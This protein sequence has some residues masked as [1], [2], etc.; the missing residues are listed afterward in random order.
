MSVLRTQFLLAAAVLLTTGTLRA[1]S[2]FPTSPLIQIGE[3]TDIFFDA[4]AS[5]S[6]TD[7][8]YSSTNKVSGTS[9]SLA[10]GF[11]LEY[12]KDSPIYAT[13]TMQRAQVRYLG[14]STLSALDS[15][16]DTITG[17]VFIDQGGPLKVTLRSSYVESTRNDNLTSLGIDGSQ[18]GETLVRQGNYLHDL[19]LDYRLTEITFVGL[20]FTNSYNRY[21]N[22]VVIKTETGALPPLAAYNYNYNTNGL[23]E[24]NTKDIELRATYQY[25]GDRLKYGFTYTHSQ[26]DFS[27]A[28]Y[29][30]GTSPTGGT[31]TRA[32][33]IFK[34]VKNV[35][36]LNTTG[37]LTRSGKLRADASVGFSTTTVSDRVAGDTKN[38]GLTYAIGLKHSLTDLINHEINLSR[39]TATTPDG[40]D[41]QTNSY[42][43]AISYSASDS[44]SVNFRLSKSDVDAGPT[45]ISTLGYNLG[46]FYNYNSHL[47]LSASLNIL[48]TQFPGESG[49]DFQSKGLLIQ[50]TFRY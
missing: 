7:N 19:K 30:S 38:S 48:D 36:A 21:L 6:S 37:A 4:V 1:V 39:S 42:V 46:A 41:S 35:F 32:V 40:A 15:S 50:A 17:A 27:A 45:Q 22:P 11:S 33:D 16:Q 29:Y 23:S 20:S 2:F 13:A 14:A 44:L 43:Y 8:L 47:N 9:L 12:A 26:N 25:P 18:L 31:T 24:I 49:K 34:S 3:D 5:L 28:P 10:P